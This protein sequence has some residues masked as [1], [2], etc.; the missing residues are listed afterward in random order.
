MSLKEGDIC[1]TIRDCKMYAGASLEEG[2]VVQLDF[3][4]QIHLTS[5]TW[6]AHVTA[7]VLAGSDATFVGS[8]WWFDP[9]D[10]QKI[11]E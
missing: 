5:R 10:L 4:P 8:S 7:V 1:V 2:A 11:G 3:V 9:T 6:Q